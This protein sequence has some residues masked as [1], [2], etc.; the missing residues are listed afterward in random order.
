MGVRGNSEQGVRA[1]GGR[2]HKQATDWQIADLRRRV[3][4]LETSDERV[5]RYRWFLSDQVLHRFITARNG[6]IDVAL[7]IR[8]G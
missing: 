5:L 7:G 8:N 1:M 3:S 6:N 2:G 4:A